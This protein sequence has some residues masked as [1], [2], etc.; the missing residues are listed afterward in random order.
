MFSKYIP[1]KTE[2][3]ALKDEHLKEVEFFDVDL[4]GKIIFAIDFRINDEQDF[5]KDLKLLINKNEEEEVE[6][7]DIIKFLGFRSSSYKNKP[8]AWKLLKVQILLKEDKSNLEEVLTLLNN[9]MLEEYRFD[10]DDEKRLGIFRTFID[11]LVV[12]FSKLHT[13]DFLLKDYKLKYFSFNIIDY[14]SNYNKDEYYYKFIIN[15]LQKL[16][17]M[18][19][20][21]NEKDSDNIQVVWKDAVLY[22]LK[23]YKSN[24]EK[25]EEDE[26]LLNQKGREVHTDIKRYQKINDK[27]RD[28]KNPQIIIPEIIKECFYVKAK[29]IQ[30]LLFDL[31]EEYDYIS[32]GNFI[33]NLLQHRKDVYS[34]NTAYYPPN[35]MYITQKERPVTFFG[36]WSFWEEI[37]KKQ[38]ALFKFIFTNQRSDV[39]LFKIDNNEKSYQF[40]LEIIHKLIKK[41]P[42]LF[43]ETKRHQD[44]IKRAIVKQDIFISFI[45]KLPKLLPDTKVDLLI[46]IDLKESY[47]EAWNIIKNN[48]I[49]KI[50]NLS[51]IIENY[52]ELPLNELEIY[53]LEK[54]H[55]V[56]YNLLHIER[57]RK[58]LSYK[59]NF[60]RKLLLKYPNFASEFARD[61]EIFKDWNDFIPLMKEDKRDKLTDEIILSAIG[62]EESLTLLKEKIKSLLQSEDNT[63]M[64]CHFFKLQPFTTLFANYDE[65]PEGKLRVLSQNIL[66]TYRC[67]QRE[68]T[69]LPLA[70]IKFLYLFFP[71]HNESKTST[72][73]D[74]SLNLYKKI[75]TYLSMRLFKDDC[76]TIKEWVKN[77][78][79]KFSE[80]FI[81]KNYDYYDIIEMLGEYN[82]EEKFVEECLTYYRDQYLE[83]DDNYQK[84]KLQ[85]EFFDFFYNFLER[86]LN[87]YF[88]EKICDLE[89]IV[90]NFKIAK[91]NILNKVKKSINLSKKDSKKNMITKFKKLS[92]SD[93]K[94]LRKEMHTKFFDEAF[95]PHK[96]LTL[97][98]DIIAD[99]KEEVLLRIQKSLSKQQVNNELIEDVINSFNA[100][101]LDFPSRTALEKIINTKK[102]SLPPKFETDK[103]LDSSADEIMPSLIH[104]GISKLIS[105]GE[106]I[107]SSNID[108]KFKIPLVE[109]L[110]IVY[111]DYPQGWM[112]QIYKLLDNNKELSGSWIL[113]LCRALGNL[114]ESQGDNIPKL[115]NRCMKYPAIECS[116]NLLEE[117]KTQ[118][119]L[120]NR[121]NFKR[122]HFKNDKRRVKEM[123]SSLFKAHKDFSINTN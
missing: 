67:N 42:Q 35:N 113:G 86:G 41:D 88:E 54:K 118:K 87:I 85:K 84:E 102:E 116:A 90:S 28:L 29:T 63:N 121:E 18:K 81:Y 3:Q 57:C 14:L 105:A 11:E 98:G 47:K 76:L 5:E 73:S 70:E 8:F 82:V 17:P 123:L 33:F 53:F 109:F 46:T 45:V 110:N 15:N 30:S 48:D 44:V 66:N 72:I 68:L 26:A 115:L 40:N 119:K 104:K 117:I 36:N 10:Y 71:T 77:F 114:R 60:T 96:E 23:N 2:L 99:A 59:K 112:R 92:N 7:T 103:F 94:Y 12:S 79:L 6:L 91:T 37:Y 93:R 25:Y 49:P 32:I 9:L 56:I 80:Y 4:F 55:D 69:D 107:L 100:K 34:D 16:L 62:T 50:D 122:G 64:N 58:F 89:K 108:T 52:Q 22:H 74:P 38:P 83:K 20:L 21:I 27:I 43:F 97:L 111:Q 39:D 120:F 1:N 24:L 75:Y 31:S 78:H 13:T 19:F 101:E 95:I 106:N 65:F 51:K 61:I